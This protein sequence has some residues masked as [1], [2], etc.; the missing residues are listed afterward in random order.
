MTRLL[1]CL[2][3]S[4]LIMTFIG[5]G[6]KTGK[7]AGKSTDPD[8]AS[9]KYV[10]DKDGQKPISI[11]A[12]YNV[13]AWPNLTLMNDGTIIAIIHNQPS[14]LGQP[15]DV[16]CWASSDNGQTWQK[17]GTPAPRDNPKFARGNVAAGL[18]ANGD[19]VV[20]SSGWSNPV[21]EPGL[22][23]KVLHPLVSRS[24]DGGRTWEINENAFLEKWPEDAR[25]LWSPDGYLVPFGDILP[26]NDGMLRVGMYGD[27]PGS[28]LVYK[29]RDDGKT[30][31]EP[32][33]ISTDSIIHEPA[34]FHLGKGK[35]LL[36]AR[37]DGLDLYTSLNDAQS[38]NL[39]TRLTGKSQH[40]GHLMRLM[41]GRLLLTYGNRV[42]PRGID[43]KFSND[44]GENWSEALR[45][46]N[47]E[48]D[49]GY[50]SSVQ[51]PD[52]QVLTAY[53][54]SVVND[55]KLYH[56]GVATWDPSKTIIPCFLNHTSHLFSNKV[57]H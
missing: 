49:I 53:Y 6:K 41:D 17:R 30:W 55:Q 19:L 2:L 20:I 47:I 57:I 7:N 44:E 46:V 51:L 9:G 23:R 45:V 28:T 14:H 50:P 52:G 33:K 13:C 15:A 18:A 27:N 39:S 35:W 43:V 21:R 54:A 24:S 29:S 40:P 37:Y 16:D 10:S 42:S 34:L 8:V 31:G 48:S 32:V 5:C 11:I 38:W 22:V 12:V 1:N 56:M 26:G 25:G 36:A 3:I 4:L